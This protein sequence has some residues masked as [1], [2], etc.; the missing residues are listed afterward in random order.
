MQLAV[1]A[2]VLPP[3]IVLARAGRYGG[4]RL[5]AVLVAGVAAGGWLAARLEIPNVV[6]DLADGIGVL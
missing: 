1:V 4:L 2:L 5:V 3:L 6:A